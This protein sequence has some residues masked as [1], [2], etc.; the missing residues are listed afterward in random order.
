MT[1]EDHPSTADPIDAQL[2]DARMDAVMEMDASEPPASDGASVLDRGAD[3]LLVLA[4]DRPWRDITLRDVAERAGV[5]FADLYARAPGK[6]ALLWRLSSRFDRSAFA[7][8]ASDDQPSAKDRLFEAFMARLEA[9]EPHRAVLISLARGAGPGVFAPRL[10][11]TVRGLLEASG[12]DTSGPRGAL[13]LA[14]F[15]AA[16]A[17]TLQVWRDDEGALNRTMAEIDK[18]LTRTDRRLSRVGAGL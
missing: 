12:I 8:A 2:A 17:R 11:I 14:A 16:W 13:R 18:L 15:T 9:M 6:A 7:A 3:A 5:G 1:S 4:A 10:P